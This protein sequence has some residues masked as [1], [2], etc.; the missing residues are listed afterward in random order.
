M[1]KTE[2]NKAAATK[3]GKRKNS[4]AAGC[5]CGKNKCYQ[6]KPVIVP[7]PIKQSLWQKVLAFFRLS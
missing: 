1:S 7:E 5:I 6:P 4:K 2:K 3:T